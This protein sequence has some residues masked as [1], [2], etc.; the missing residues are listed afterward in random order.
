[1]SGLNLCAYFLETNLLAK[2]M[3]LK[4][5]SLD[6]SRKFFSL[7]KSDSFFYTPHKNGADILDA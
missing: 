4:F 1:M 3:L 2:L 7:S 5:F 6:I